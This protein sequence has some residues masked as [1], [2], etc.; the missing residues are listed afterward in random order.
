MGQRGRERQDPALA[1]Q[2]LNANQSEALEG[3]LVEEVIVRYCG[4]ILR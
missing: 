3:L 1:E 2:V 4:P